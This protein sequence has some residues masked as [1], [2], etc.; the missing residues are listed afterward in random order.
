MVLLWNSHT[1]KQSRWRFCLIRIKHYS[2]IGPIPLW[3]SVPH[4]HWCRDCETVPEQHWIIPGTVS[5]SQ[6]TPPQWKKKS[7]RIR[8]EG[9]VQGQSSPELTGILTVL[10]CI[11]CSNLEILTRIGGELWFGQAQN[12]VNFEFGVKFDL[13]GQ[14][15]L[16]PKTIGNLTKVFC[17][18]G[19][20]LVILA[21]TG[22]ELPSGQANDWYTH[23]HTDTGNDNTRRPK[24]ASGKKDTC[25]LLDARIYFNQ[26]KTY[27]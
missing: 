7:F 12:G 17:F 18:S 26:K 19:P 21:W 20:N 24:L 10:K 23:T 3:L 25:P 27:C 14:G 15:Q 9:E 5:Q 22:H 4:V 16:P 2:T 11:C 6:C 8:N 1:V 13:E